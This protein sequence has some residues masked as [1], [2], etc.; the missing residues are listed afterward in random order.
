VQRCGLAGAVGA[1]RGERAA[2]RAEG[3]GVEAAGEGQVAYRHGRGFRR[4]AR[5]ARRTAA[6]GDG[7]H[8]VV[9]RGRAIPEPITAAATVTA[10]AAQRPGGEGRTGSARDER[11]GAGSCSDASRRAGTETSADSH[12]RTPGF[13]A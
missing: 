11:R 6:W 7:V 1:D 10:T 5:G 9:L 8:H 4:G 12:S 13:S 2:G 3:A